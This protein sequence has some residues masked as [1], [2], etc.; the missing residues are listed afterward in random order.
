MASNSYRISGYHLKVARMIY[1]FKTQ[2]ELGQELGVSLGTIQRWEGADVVDS[3][4]LGVYMNDLHFD[5]PRIA[6]F[7]EKSKS[8]RN[9]KRFNSTRQFVQLGG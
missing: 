5:I 4:T 2:E 1:G 3:K 8:E 6:L 7:I 9:T